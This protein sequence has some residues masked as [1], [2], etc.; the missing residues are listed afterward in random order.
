LAFVTGTLASFL[1]CFII[2]KKKPIDSIN[3]R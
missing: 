3:D 2:S 1:P